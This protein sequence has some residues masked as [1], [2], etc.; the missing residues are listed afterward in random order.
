M[1]I[2]HVVSWNIQKGVGMDFRRDLARTTHVLRAMGADVIGL[3]EVLRTEQQDQAAHV[4]G[5]LDM[6]FAWGP[7]R[8]VRRGTY[9]NA[10]FVRGRVLEERVHDLSVPRCEPRACL[11]ALIES[12]GH[13]ARFFVCHFGLGF[14]ERERQAARLRVILDASSREAPRI[15]LGDFNEWQRGGPVHRAIRSAFPS[16]PEPRPT[17]PSFL[18]VFALDRIAWDDA[19]RGEVHVADVWG[20]SDHRLL[21]TSLESIGTPQ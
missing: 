21:R 5:A 10:L 1:A 15:V 7:A 14:R 16:A 18:P 3:Q 4:A 19:L 6:S 17:H 11:E 9:G 12:R 2:L 20:A 13:V 8:A